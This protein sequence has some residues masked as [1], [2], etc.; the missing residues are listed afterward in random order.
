MYPNNGFYGNSYMNPNMPPM[1]PMGY[2]P[3]GYPPM[4]PMNYPP[5]G[6]A[7]MAVGASMQYQ[8]G[9]DIRMGQY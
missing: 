1:S 9:M 7:P 3:M 6:Y 5:M 4:T 2:T 8:G